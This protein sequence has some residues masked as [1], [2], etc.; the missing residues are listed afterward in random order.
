MSHDTDKLIR[1]LSLV[2]YLMAERRPLTARDVK[3][4]VEGYSEMS[5]EAF[6]RRFYS[7]RAELIGLG[8]PLQSQRDEFTGEELY[9]LRSE[10]YF[11]PALELTDEELAA[12]Q[13]SLYLLE[14]KF[15]YAEPLRLALQNLA[16]GRPGFAEPPSATAVRVEVLDPD[17][18]PE[19]PGRLAKLEGAISKQRTVKF[20]YESI[21]RGD[22][23]E[24]TLNPFALYNDGGRWYVVGQDLD[25]ADLR[26][27]RV[28]RIRGEIRFATRRERDFRT[29]VEFDVERFRGRPP[30]QIGDLTG[31]ARIEVKGD[32]AWWVQRSYGETGRLD[33]GVFVTDY[34]S[35]ALLASWVLRQDG[36]AVPVEPDELRR[37]VARALRTVREAHEGRPPA[38]AAERPRPEADS[39][40]ERPAGPVA[41]ERFAVL[42]ALLAYLLAAC[43]DGTDA[44]IS[45]RELVER[46]SI[47]EDELQEHLSLLNLVN[48]G[49][50]C[51]TVYAELDEAR[52]RVHVDKELY[53]ETFRAAPRLTPLEAR[54]IRLALEYVGPMIAADAHT[55][56]DRVRRKLEETFGQFELAQTP[57]P[58]VGTPEEKLV[59]VFSEAIEKRRLVEIE[60]QKEGEQTWSQRLVEPYS[61]ER[62][63]PNWRVHTWD[64]TR[65]GERS[66]R[67]DRM[68]AARLAKERFE[69]R[70]GFEPSGL[71]DARTAKVLYTKGIARWAL[72]RGARPLRDGT[73]LADLRVG[74]PEWLASEIF[75]YR[76]DA[77][78][79]EPADLRSG[80]AAR[81]KELLQELGVARLRVKA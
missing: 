46:F 23:A 25:R 53:G 4:N 27:F 21:S 68:R 69:P 6:A 62:E 59:R 55:P 36:R 10:Q 39:S 31:E 65:D 73:A 47:P 16:L 32:T 63:L 51:Y 12:L 14:G 64:R 19:M 7:D 44:E 3:S 67:L 29:P 52:E 37:E 35:P 33:D 30:W 66:F 74:S 5:D 18:S 34:S 49:G 20:E 75:S 80:I 76:G 42:Q 8:V 11:L 1:Q 50:G 22:T 60:Y 58:A 15:A 48:F 56:L 61:L 79:L 26:T 70:E 38:V 72:E 41:P 81:A 43:G 13:T 28:S 2:A 45:A 17:Y 78:V 57:E 54:A 9:T 40:G 24:R 77:I 71:R